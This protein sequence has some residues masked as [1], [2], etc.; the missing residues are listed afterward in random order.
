MDTNRLKEPAFIVGMVVLVLLVA[1][2]QF[3]KRQ[4]DSGLADLKELLGKTNTRLGQLEEQ[5]ANL[6][7]NKSGAEVLG[8]LAD[9]SQQFDDALQL[10][11]DQLN[12]GSF[13]TSYDLILVAS[14]LRPTDPRLFDSLLTFLEK[15][16][17]SED[18]DAGLLADDLSSRGEA[19]IHFQPP[20]QVEAARQ[21]FNKVVQRPTSS[22][23]TAALPF[24]EVIQL[25]AVAENTAVPV[26]IRTR[27]ADQAR[28]VL[29]ELLLN[30]AAAA[31]GEDSNQELAK[32]VTTIQQ[33]IDSSEL[34]CVNELFQKAKERTNSWLSSTKTLLKES[35]AV[36]A[37]ATPSVVRRMS[38]AISTGVDLVQELTPYSKTSVSESADLQKQVE[39]QVTILQRTKTW[40]YNQQ[41]LRLIRDIESRKDLSTEE[42]IRF[43]AEVGEEHLS[44]YILR[45][46]NELWEKV[47][48][49]LKDEEKKAWAVRLRIL[50]VKE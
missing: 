22:P 21:R 36:A 16:R 37:D 19:L 9:E 17:A 41:V 42:K 43:L 7:T 18:E 33:R 29:S 10:A 46:H 45:R 11:Q 23:E 38:S 14:R 26:S 1:I 5:L 49:E 27:A 50:Q 32:E 25:L 28:K 15:A 13:A 6:P 35:E 2:W 4:T 8:S 20:K 34:A 24:S 44:P 3:P 48:E 31:G 47:F 12:A 30:R 39:K 40:L